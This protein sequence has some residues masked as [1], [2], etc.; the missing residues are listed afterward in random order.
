MTQPVAS[1]RTKASQGFFTRDYGKALLVALILAV[2][3]YIGFKQLAPPDAA[4]TT[5]SSS[6][7]SSGRAMRHLEAIAQRPHPVG[8]PD[9]ARVR[10]YILAEA[11]ALGFTPE[12]QKATALK[13]DRG[14]PILGATVE[15]IF[16][17]LRGSGDGQALLF[18]AHYDSVPTGP[19]ASDDGASVAALLETMRALKE[20][21]PLK[22]DVAFL[23]TD[24]EEVGLLGAKAFVSEH[25]AMKDVKVV[26][27]FE[28][29]GN[30][31]PSIMFETSRD[32]GW[33]IDQFAEAVSHPVANSLSYEIYR[34]LPNDTDLTVFK[35]AGVASLNF[36]Y[37]KGINYYHTQLD[38]REHIDERSLQHHGS[39]ALALAR[40]F[41]NLDLGQ[42]RQSDAVYFNIPGG[43]LIRYSGMWVFPLVIVTALLFAAVV[44]VGL[45]R[46]RLSL[47][48]IFLGLVAFVASMIAV[49]VAAVIMSWITGRLSA[50]PGV[51][52]QA[53][54]YN[55]HLYFISLIALAIGL[56]SALYLWFRKRISLQ[57]LT[58]GALLVW[59][60]L[61]VVTALL[62]PGASYLFTWPLLFSLIALLLT[63]GDDP[64]SLKRLLI[65]SL[66]ALPGLVL[67]APMIYMVYLA[68]TLGVAAILGVMAVLVLGLLIPHL[69]LTSMRGRWVLPASALLISAACYVA[70]SLGSGFDSDHRLSNSAFYVMSADTERAVW[71][72][73]NQSPD[74]WSSQFFKE[75]IERGSLDDYMVSG[76][77]GYMKSQAQLASLEAPSIETIGESRENGNRILRLLVKSVRRAPIITVSADAGTEVLSCVVNGRRIAHETGRRWGL[78]YYNLPAEGLEIAL[79]LKSPEPVKLRATDLSYGLPELP[80]FSPRPR[81]DHMMPSPVPYND[82]TLISKSFS[83]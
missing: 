61:A 39:Y 28:A 73:F 19:G 59:L 29:R 30:G 2:G 75:N 1:S 72:S 76:F 45:R 81:P 36:A 42:P 6:D 60:V 80:G 82:S 55:S 69:A 49:A 17:R 32:N 12:V 71:A 7:F 64:G 5:V 24:A 25:P 22:T 83:F 35:D 3:L 11:T 56:T 63:F 18:V 16:V 44:F 43:F 54:A 10:D 48:G 77:T 23:F 52:G 26:L 65:F 31:G 46:K 20:G 66:L 27:N 37:I 8:S 21:P 50:W 13:D 38:S 41:G 70:A 4:A 78:R 68:M 58:A 14:F 40:H 79:E 51:S 57:N 67:L 62:V 33:L 15:N 53:E 34:R 9:L 74:E 47:S